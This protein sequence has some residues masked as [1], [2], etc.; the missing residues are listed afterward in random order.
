MVAI[1]AAAIAPAAISVSPA[2]PFEIIP[3]QGIFSN[4]A[5][6][7]VLDLKRDLRARANR[8]R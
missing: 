6:N 2:S 7:P 4:G 3:Q 8:S 5:I 1:G